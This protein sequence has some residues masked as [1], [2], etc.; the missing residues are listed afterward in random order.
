MKQ[1]R[2]DTLKKTTLT[3]KGKNKATGKRKGKGK[4]KG[5]KTK[6]DDDLSDISDDDAAIYLECT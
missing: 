1:I 6:N 3:T 4:G 2:K 5:K